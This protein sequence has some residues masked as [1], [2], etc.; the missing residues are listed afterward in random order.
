MKIQDLIYVKA[1][2]EE[3]NITRAAE[4]LFIAQPS[5]SQA[6]QRIESEL[7]VKLFTRAPKGLYP[8]HIGKRYY[9]VAAKILNMCNAFEGEVND[10]NNQFSGRMQIGINSLFSRYVLPSILPEFK[11]KYPGIDI[12]ILE[13]SSRALEKSLLSCE[14]DFAILSTTKY[15]V[16]PQLNYELLASDPIVII[17]KENSHLSKICIDDPRYI[18]PLLELKHIEN[19]PLIMLQSGSRLRNVVYDLLKE[20]NIKPNII[21][22]I[23][24]LDAAFRLVAAGAGITFSPAPF[25]KFQNFPG[26]SVYSI[27]RKNEPIWLTNLVSLRGSYFP[28]SNSYFINL[29]KNFF[30]SNG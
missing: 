6:L 8:T 17:A 3:K 26:L 22:D 28:A 15:E 30:A 24:N 9:E 23:R 1:I 25:F 11:K 14:I 10:Y 20:A 2:V 5:L 27:S 12:Y 29:A 16:S 4:K 18:Y 19:E 13:D 7:N 21:M